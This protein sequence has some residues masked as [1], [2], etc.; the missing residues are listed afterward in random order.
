MNKRN[1][2]SRNGLPKIGP[3][4]LS[5]LKALLR[6]PKNRFETLASWFRAEGVAGG[7]RESRRQSCWRVIR[8]GWAVAQWGA[9]GLECT[10]TPAGRDIAEGGIKVK[11]VGRHTKTSNPIDNTSSQAGNVSLASVRERLSSEQQQDVDRMTPTARELFLEDVQDRGIET[12]LKGWA[13]MV[14]QLESFG[15]L[16]P[17]PA[18]QE[19]CTQPEPPKQK[20]AP[21]GI[22][23]QAGTNW[24]ERL[25]SALGDAETKRPALPWSNGDLPTLRRL[26]REASGDWNDLYRRRN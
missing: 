2:R 21:T 12:V 26:Q 11:I 7:S 6:P 5:L 14:A 15:E 16:H 24:L 17:R 19:R 9:H 18:R 13:L 20:P 25:A 3:N 10:L 22:S 4:Q 23:R 8:A 1:A